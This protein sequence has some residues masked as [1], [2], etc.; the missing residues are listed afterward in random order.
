MCVCVYLEI[1]RLTQ[2]M[3]MYNDINQSQVWF[4]CSLCYVYK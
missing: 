2:K 3:A 4:L 1:G